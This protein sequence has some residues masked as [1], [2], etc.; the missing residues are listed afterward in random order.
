MIHT[1]TKRLGDLILAF[2]NTDPL[3]GGPGPRFS[4]RQSVSPQALKQRSLTVQKPDSYTRSLAR[5]PGLSWDFLRWTARLRRA[6]FSRISIMSTDQ[7]QEPEVGPLSDGTNDYLQEYGP[8]VAGGL[9]AVLLVV[10]LVV[11]FLE[12]SQA[13]SEAVWARFAQA[14]TAGDSGAY[15]S[16]A[17]EFP[18]HP[19]GVWARLREAQAYLQEAT[20]LQATDRAAANAE[21]KKAKEAL[22]AFKS[23]SHVPAD[24][25][26]Q[27]ELCN[28]WLLEATC[29]GNTAEVVSAYEEFRK[30]YP[31]SYYD[32]YLEDR[33]A[34]LGTKDA[35]EFYEWFDEQNPRPED[36]KSPADGGFQPQAPITLPAIP[37]ELYPSD[38]NEL[39]LPDL[40]SLDGVTEEASTPEAGTEEKPEEER[41]AETP[42]EEKPSNEKPAESSESN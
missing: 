41:P 40:P 18:D 39:K 4:I 32:A 16:I 8:K 24:A 38:W 13:D 12:G 3:S 25:K 23:L 14:Q 35:K 33:I 6:T 17:D 21:F 10:G 11:Y 15:A 7:T 26:L 36:R 20:R 5:L 31:R 34:A 1:D 9:V 37:Q 22:E 2:V 42:A 27:A 28:A 30:N 29:D 19:V